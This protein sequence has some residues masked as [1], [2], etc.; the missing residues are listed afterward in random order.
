VALST[1]PVLFI[2]VK[3]MSSK[4]F[5]QHFN[6]NTLLHY[7]VIAILLGGFS[8][9]AIQTSSTWLYPEFNFNT[10]SLNGLQKFDSKEEMITFLELKPTVN[11]HWSLP[12]LRSFQKFA[13]IGIDAVSEVES[14]SA[15][16]YSGTNIQVEGVD[17]AD[18]VKTDGNYIYLAND[19]KILIIKAYPPTEAGIVSVID[20]EYYVTDVFISDDKLVAIYAPEIYSIWYPYEI[21]VSEEPKRNTTIKVFDISDRAS[22]VLERTVEADGFYITSRMINN[23]VYLITSQPA[24]LNNNEPILPR[25]SS[26]EYVYEA[27]PKEIWYNNK[28]DYYHSYTNVVTINVQ[29]PKEWI[30]HETFLLSTSSTIYVSQENIYLTSPWWIQNTEVDGEV[31]LVYKIQV[32]NSDI[33]YI[34]DGLVPG[35]VLNQFSMDEYDGYFR[36]ATTLG[37]VSRNGAKT[38]NNIYVLNST[39]GITGTLEG[40]APGEDIYS[41]R[42]MSKKCYLVTFKK[43][44]PLFV[45]DLSDPFKPKVLGKLKIPGYSD[46]L[47]PYDDNT[48]IGIGKETIEA[49]EGNFAWYQGVKISL[50]DVSDVANPKELDKFE[51][52]DRGTDSPALHN[53][54][55][56]LFSR[57][58]NLLVIPVLEAK[59][60]PERYAGEIPPYTH[61]EYVNQGAFVFKI[62]KENGIQLRGF[63]THIEDPQEFLKS[64]YWFDSDYSV[65]RSL[66]IENVL[67]TISQG[68]IKMNTLDD[69]SEVGKVLL[70]LET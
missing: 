59:I 4:K 57:S 46:Y 65:E 29:N 11:N 63:V 51:I 38:S 23:Y 14:Q 24:T 48:L 52:G 13:N 28:T 27:K 26:N 69:L 9:S 50:F 45:I 44:D 41:A 62:S 3:K 1:F 7:A 8:M 17:E 58:R 47:H 21:N 5:N 6:K 31:T 22:P 40:L 42:F 20:M 30:T 34:A 55:A 36:I 33:E 67:Y 49:E 10:N 39:L 12:I 60:D 37:Y 68:M 16:D 19:K 32:E 53:H 66:Y 64:G 2:Q 70:Q 15:P 54:K 25:F 43:V 18:I 35:R 56:F 61:G